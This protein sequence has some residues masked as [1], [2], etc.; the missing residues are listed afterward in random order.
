MR[1]PR[2]HVDEVETDVGLVRRLLREQFPEWTGLPLRPVRESGTVNALYRLGDDL[3]VRIPRNRPSPWSDLVDDE[4]TWLPRLAP[5]LPVKVPVPVARGRPADGCPHEWGIFEWLPGENPVPGTVP[6]SVAEELAVFVRTLHALDLP[7]GPDSVRG[8]D[9]GRFDEFTRA[10]LKALEGELDTVSAEALWDEA[11]ALPPWPQDPIWIHADLM[12]GNLLIE[13]GRLGAVIDWGGSGMGDPAVDLMVA[14]N[15]LPPSGRKVFREA[16][17]LDDDT[18]ARGRGWALWTGLGGIPYYRETF[19]AFVA[20][21]RHTVG[22]IL[23]EA[24]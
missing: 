7:G 16:L 6:D 2:R 19:P 21:A 9:L 10:N 20:D 14:W 12:P 5:L 13:G 3:V 17:D 15:L 23:A 1:V 22:E 8:S 18:W 11:L 4:L 24:P